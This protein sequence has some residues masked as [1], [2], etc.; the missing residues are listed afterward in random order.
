[1]AGGAIIG[2]VAPPGPTPA[3]TSPIAYV[4]VVPLTRK[5]SST[6]MRLIGPAVDSGCG[7]SRGCTPAVHTIVAVGISV[8]SCSTTPAASADVTRVLGRTST[9]S[10]VS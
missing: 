7:R 10:R 6:A 5:W 8:P 2:R 9:P 3:A 4:L 1:M